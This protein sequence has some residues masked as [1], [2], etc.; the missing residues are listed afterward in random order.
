AG[1]DT[2]V[3]KVEAGALLFRLALVAAVAVLDLRHGEF[4]RLRIAELGEL[5]NH[6]AAG[7]AQPQQLGDFIE[8]FSGGIVSGVAD[9]LVSPAAL[10]LF[11]QVEVRMSAGNHQRQ[12]RKAQLAV[13]LL[14]LF[15]QYGV[16]MAI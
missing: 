13:A 14:L 6:W 9:V 12:Q 4:D 7:I 5:V 8:G 10:A 2:T 15:Q 1:F 11:S 3:R 16:D